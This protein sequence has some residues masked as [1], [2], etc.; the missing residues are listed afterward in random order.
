[1]TKAQ[2][3]DHKTRTPK[4]APQ[5]LLREFLDFSE[6]FS[7]YDIWESEAWRVRRNPSSESWYVT[8]LVEPKTR[9]YLTKK[10][11]IATIGGGAS[12]RAINSHDWPDVPF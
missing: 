12:G 4:G 9:Q 1:M 2:G 5:T 7:D 8:R 6:V 11:I 3:S 10:E